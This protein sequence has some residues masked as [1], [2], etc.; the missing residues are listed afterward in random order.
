MNR[1]TNIFIFTSGRGGIGKT[2]T[3]AN[4]SDWLLA[5]RKEHALISAE[6]HGHQ[7]RRFTER[8]VEVQ[9]DEIAIREGASELDRIFAEASRARHVVVDTGANT[10]R[11]LI[12]WMNSISFYDICEQHEIYSTLCVV[13]GSGDR[14][15][16]EFFTKF[17][18]FSG[19]RTSWILFRAKHT[20]QD[21]ELFDEIAGR[22]KARVFDLPVVP[23]RLIEASQKRCLTFR[24]LADLHEAD[25]LLR[26]RCRR[27]AREFE[28]CFETLTKEFA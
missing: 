11:A 13:A 1:S 2:T 18:E 4:F 3:A 15:T 12:D 6:I 7:L 25:L 9:V 24:Q 8:A 23:A 20:G 26:Q 17:F 16:L 14:D 19:N 27:V 21:F 10:G 22:A 28:S 5:E